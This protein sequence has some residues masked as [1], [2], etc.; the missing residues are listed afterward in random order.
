MLAILAAPLLGADGRI[1]DWVHREQGR[2]TACETRPGPGS[3]RGRQ[4]RGQKRRGGGKKEQGQKRWRRRRRRGRG[5]KRSR[6]EKNE[7]MSTKCDAEEAG[8]DGGG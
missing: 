1:I 3:R 2:E 8:G 7:L 4:Q 6:E 5:R